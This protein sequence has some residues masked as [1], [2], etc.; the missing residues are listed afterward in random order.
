MSWHDR[1]WLLVTARKPPS[2]GPYTDLWLPAP[3]V[4][5]LHITANAW[6]SQRWRQLCFLPGDP[7]STLGSRKPLLILLT[8]SVPWGPTE[9][10]MEHL[11]LQMCPQGRGKKL[12]N[13]C[14]LLW[15]AIKR[16]NTGVH[17]DIFSL[18]KTLIL[19]IFSG[20]LAQ[21][22]WGALLW[23][24]PVFELESFLGVSIR[25]ENTLRAAGSWKCGLF[26]NTQ[27]LQI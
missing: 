18:S 14:S 8:R 6:N 24:S 27:W 7:G 12:H 23:S 2:R 11:Q 19:Q 26:C 10:C 4:L 9:L 5:T 15:I 22:K 20:F 1:A 21:I 25:E 16:Q 17:S 13:K 3:N